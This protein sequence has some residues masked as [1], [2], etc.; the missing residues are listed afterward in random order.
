MQ[1][2]LTHVLIQALWLILPAYLPNSAAAVIGGTRPIDGGREYRGTRLLG[3]GKTWRGLVAGISAGFLLAV[4]LNTL[5]PSVSA[6]FPFTL[7]SFSIMAAFALPTGAMLGDLAA[8]FI[9]RRMDRERGAPVPG[10][11]QLDF[12]IGA[13]VLGAILAP[14][15]ID[16][17]GTPGIIVLLVVTPL[18]HL[19]ANLI[20]YKI[21]VKDEPW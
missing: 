2:P 14:A 5:V 8:S 6:L 15:W 12:I 16:A 17:L 13:L 3:D 19:S 18:V 7:P 11:D 10:L 20:G 9:K 21:G 4:L 1:E